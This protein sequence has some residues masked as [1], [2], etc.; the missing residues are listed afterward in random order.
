VAWTGAN[1]AYSYNVYRCQKACTTS[2]G[3][4][5]PAATYWYRVCLH[6]VGLSCTDTAAS[7]TQTP[8]PQVGGTG[9]TIANKNGV[10]AP[11]AQAGTIST[12]GAAQVFG[13][14]Q[15]S[16]TAACETNYGVT[17]LA[18]RYT[19]TN[20]GLDCLPANA[21]IDAI[22]YRITTTITTA[23]SF[24]IGDA[25]TANRFCTTQSKLTAGNTGICIAQ[26]GSSAAIQNAASS[27]RV[28]TNAIPGAGAIRLIVYYHTWN[29]PAN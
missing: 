14:A 8:V 18:T 12:G 3:A 17:T 16:T 21:I 7:P 27:V 23:A 29:P 11:V 10:Y 13:S 22:V 19:T 1:G 24:T 9:T 15:N 6:I 5:N 20:T 26:A 2:D 25:G 4:P 28:T